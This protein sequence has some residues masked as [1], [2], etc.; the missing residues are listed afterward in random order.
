MYDEKEQN[1]FKNVRTELLELIPD[2]NKNG[3]MLEI[4]AG[5]GNTLLYA[6]KK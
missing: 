3:T 2:E 4:G 6:K 5:G 1:Y